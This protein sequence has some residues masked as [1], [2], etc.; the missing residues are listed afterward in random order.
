MSNRELCKELFCIAWDL[1]EERRGIVLEA[2]RRLL[3]YGDS[4]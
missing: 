4:R 2:V 3:K 1:S